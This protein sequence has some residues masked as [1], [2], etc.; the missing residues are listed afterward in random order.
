VRHDKMLWTK[1]ALE[2]APT[3][4]SGNPPNIKWIANRL[5]G[6][7]FVD[8]GA[9]VGVF[10]VAVMLDCP[11]ATCVAFEP[12][13]RVWGAFEGLAKKNG[14]WGR[15]DLH[16]LA[17]RDEIGEGW[18]CVPEERNVSG[19]ATLAENPNFDV[20]KRE[21]VQV[22]TLDNWWTDEGKPLV[23]VVKVDC[24]GAE[25]DILAGGQAMFAS[26]VPYL[27]IEIHGP[28]LNEHGLTVQDL[29]D[30]L[31]ALGF[32]YTQDRHNL[33]CEREL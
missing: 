32:E 26:T 17:L 33:R 16:K 12:Q 18:L 29:T 11:A 14:V 2:F 28:T 24:Q 9:N 7:L 20:A 22:T 25:V 15:I 31:D 27:F 10:S 4:L 6:G 13:S 1:E 3:G 21:Q 19:W 30:A 23:R 5:E 8:A